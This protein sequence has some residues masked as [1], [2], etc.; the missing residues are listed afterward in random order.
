MPIYTQINSR[1]SKHF[2]AVFYYANTGIL[3]TDSNRNIVAVNPFALKKFGYTEKELIGKKVEK[4]VPLRFRK[5]HRSHH[6]KYLEKAPQRLMGK[7]LEVYARKK[8]GTEF[9]V[10]VNLSNYE[11]NNEKYVITFIN[12]ITERKDIQHEIEKLQ[13]ELEETVRYRTKTLNNALKQL[14][15]TNLEL[16]NAL[17]L[18]RAIINNAGAMIIATDIKGT[19]ILFNKEASINIGYTPEQVIG[20][21]T[22]LEFHDK[23][24]L[25][26]KREEISREFGVQ[27]MTDFEAMVEKAKRGIHNEEEFSYIRKNGT[28]FPVLLTIT[29]IKNNT[30]EITGY[31][32]VSIDIADRKKV[33]EDLVIALEKEKELSD[34][35]SRFVSMASHEFR[36]PLSTVLSSAYLIERYAKEEDQFKREKH[37]HRIISSVQILTD[38][39][40]DFLNVDKIEE[41]KVQVRPASFNIK[42]LVIST[43]N[44]MK[45]SLKRK[46]KIHY[47]HEGEQ[48]VLMDLS[49]L[50]HI[51]MNVVSNASKFSPEDSSIEMK[52]TNN[53]DNLLF[54]IKDHGMGIS[55][56]DQKHLMDRFFRGANAL[57]IQGT[58]LG[59]HI[60]SKYAK[61]MEGQVKILSELEKGTEV[62]ISFNIKPNR[63]E[64]DLVN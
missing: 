2:E 13:S 50:K 43:I 18:K 54:A 56:A 48:L 37:V 31:M 15:K 38:I 36:T 27:E 32:G 21:L 29:A 11:K 10:E 35:K 40:N 24:E 6:E 3:I 17:D 7:G 8:D 52:T 34:L 22:P 23:N 14:R 49:M 33:E 60:V 39:L 51:I 1:R 28:R 12:D 20:K 4:L 19:I 5:K 61:L 9:P 44:E 26:N 57:H 25:A 59:L 47:K 41:G 63:N 30:G 62:I 42:E 53:Q 55:V 46:Q 16:E 64:K 58:G 45:G